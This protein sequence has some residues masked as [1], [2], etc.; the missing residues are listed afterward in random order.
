VDGV[1]H[2]R[3]LHERAPLERARQGVALEAGDPSPEADVAG[4]RV[5]VL[6]TADLLD[7]A[8]ER[9]AP[10]LEQQ[11]RA[12]SARFSSAWVSTRSAMAGR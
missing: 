9:E 4:R 6:Q 1:A 12:S 11:L 7:R 10:P 2:Q 5:L 3:R 8:G